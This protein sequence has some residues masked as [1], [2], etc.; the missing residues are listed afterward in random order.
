VR[1]IRSAL[2]RVLGV[3]RNKAKVFGSS[4]I[5]RRLLRA[6]ARGI[7]SPVNCCVWYL[8]DFR[9]RSLHKLG[10]YGRNTS[11]FPNWLDVAP[12]ARSSLPGGRE[13]RGGIGKCLPGLDRFV[14][15]RARH[16]NRFVRMGE[17]QLRRRLLFDRPHL[18]PP[19][20][21][22]FEYSRGRAYPPDDVDSRPEFNSTTSQRFG[23][24]PLASAVQ[25]SLFQSESNALDT[26]AIW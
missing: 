10:N 15:R 2:A 16:G 23:L 12:Q 3:A 22:H 4:D 6:R 9:P 7:A 21:R 8:S 24:E 18:R 19:Y 14:S 1:Q 26:C 20:F 5:V 25:S 11:C 13:G 17:H